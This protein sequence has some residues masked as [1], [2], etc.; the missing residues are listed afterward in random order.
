MSKWIGVRLGSAA[1]SVRRGRRGGV[2]GTGG[3]TR[4]RCCRS[5]H[6]VLL[7]VGRAPA[8]RGGAMTRPVGVRSP[9][10]WARR[11]AG[12][13]KLERPRREVVTGVPCSRLVTRSSAHSAGRVVK[14]VTPVRSVVDRDV[15]AAGARRQEVPQLSPGLGRGAVVGDPGEATWSAL[16]AGGR[17]H[18]TWSERPCLFSS[19]SEPP[20][21][22]W[23]DLVVGRRQG[24]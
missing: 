3:A 4:L 1:R 15:V 7:W 13:A 2:V 8:R 17:R 23:R 12:G 21:S 20:S 9:E 6:L 24:D 5:A 22:R 16:A 18:W 19:T 14:N 11:G 10:L